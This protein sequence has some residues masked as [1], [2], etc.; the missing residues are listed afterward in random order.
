V[1]RPESAG[2]PMTGLMAWLHTTTAGSPD[3]GARL[4]MAAALHGVT[5]WDIFPEL[6]DDRAY[7]SRL[8]AEDWDS[9]EDEGWQ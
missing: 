9:P 7:V 1:E 3:P 6:S 2:H 4:R 5:G 8:W